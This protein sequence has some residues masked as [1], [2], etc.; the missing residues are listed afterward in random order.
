MGDFR[1][2]GTEGVSGFN[3]SGEVSG[4]AITD[5]SR[6]PRASSGARAPAGRGFGARARGGNG[7]QEPLLK[8]GGRRRRRGGGPARCAFWKEA[9]AS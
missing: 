6:V 7:E 4:F 3:R 2:I 1:S 9:D 5:R 8:R